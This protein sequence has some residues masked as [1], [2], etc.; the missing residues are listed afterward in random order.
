[1]GWIACGIWVYVTWFAIETLSTEKF[2]LNMWHNKEQAT[3]TIPT[4][5]ILASE[6]MVI[7][8]YTLHRIALMLRKVTCHATE[9]EFQDNNVVL[10]LVLIRLNVESL[11][12]VTPLQK[13][14]WLF[15]LISNSHYFLVFYFVAVYIELNF[16]S[17]SLSLFFSFT[18]YLQSTRAIVF[19]NKVELTEHRF[20][21]TIYG[22]S[23]AIPS[24]VLSLFMAIELKYSIYG[25]LNSL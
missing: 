24:P 17:F 2:S 21:G 4:F 11:S 19:H 7:L 9:I 3:N 18:L 25:L 5:G 23:F 1:M 15:N 14:T 22:R 16:L 13:H 12:Y 6:N 10:T 20:F 8:S